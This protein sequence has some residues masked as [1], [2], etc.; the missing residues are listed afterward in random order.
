MVIKLLRWLLGWVEFEVKDTSPERFLNMAYK[1]GINMWNFKSGK[2]L[3]GAGVRKSDLKYLYRIAERTMSELYIIAYHGLPFL[4]KRY[5]GRCGL[6]IGLVLWGA[7]IHYLTGFVWNIRVD[8]PSYINE[9]ELRQEMKKYGMYEGARLD[10]FEE[11]YVKN[12]LF[13]SDNRISWITINVIG[14]EAEVKVSPSM[15]TEQQEEM[16]VFNI[17]SRA[18]GTVTRME[19]RNGTA[20]IKIGE[21]IKKGQMLVSGVVEY[22]DGSS[23]LVNSEARIYAQ[24][25]RSITLTIPKEYEFWKKSMESTDKVSINIMGVELPMTL[26]GTLKEKYTMQLER[27]QLIL[28]EKRVPIYFLREHFEQY[29]KQKVVFKEKQA[30]KVLKNKLQLYEFFMLYS[31]EKATI[32][33]S[34]YQFSSDKRN[35]IL[36]VDYEIEEDVAEKSPIQVKE[37]FYRLK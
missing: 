36:T 35:Y 12:A 23:D 21:G 24:T 26:S 9:Y 34:Q 25:R 15:Q 37:T 4:L 14:T 18:D 13:A 20:Q 22:T 19:V 32:L 27:Q 29:E 6:I 3:F 8:V 10:S 31:A 2:E 28:L 17:K 33:N 7:A 16:N 5:R 11:E 30:K 1:N